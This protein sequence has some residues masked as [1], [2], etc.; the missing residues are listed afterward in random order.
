MLTNESALIENIVCNL[1]LNRVFSGLQFQNKSVF[2]DSLK[3]TRSQFSM[4]RYCGAND[5]FRQVLKRIIDIVECTTHSVTSSNVSVFDTE[6]QRLRERRKAQ[7]LLNH[8]PGRSLS[9]CRLC[10]R[11]KKRFAVLWTSE[12][13][14]RNPN[15]LTAISPVWRYNTA[16]QACGGTA[17]RRKSKWSTGSSGPSSRSS[18]VA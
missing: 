15:R 13:L 18:P 8:I 9:L 2:V 6:T 17:C 12:S 1:S 10:C 14:C 7:A 16:S 3:K 11:S 4:H 5:L